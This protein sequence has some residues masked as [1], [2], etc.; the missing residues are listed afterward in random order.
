MREIDLISVHN[1]FFTDNGFSLNKE[2]SFFEKHYP[3][4]KQ[5]IFIHYTKYPESNF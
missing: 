5:T 2:F 3:H 1:Q 4:G